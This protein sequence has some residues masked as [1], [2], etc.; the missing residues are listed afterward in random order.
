[1]IAWQ[2]GKDNE[3]NTLVYRMV[4]FRGLDG[5]QRK[6]ASFQFFSRQRGLR[7]E[8]GIGPR[9][10]MTLSAFLAARAEVS[11]SMRLLFSL[12]NDRSPMKEAAR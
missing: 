5:R 7:C 12:T 4:K 8:N 6:V 1:V 2:N 3:E 9:S 10:P 11:R